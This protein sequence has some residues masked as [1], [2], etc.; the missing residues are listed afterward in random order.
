MQ[1]QQWHP[2][3]PFR[4]RIR[5]GGDEAL[6][7]SRLERLLREMRDQPGRG[8]I[9]HAGKDLIQV[10]TVEGDPRRSVVVKR[11]ARQG[12]LRDWWA[13]WHGTAAERSFD[14]AGFL[15]RQGL[16]TPEPWACVERWERGR[17]RESFF[18]SDYLEGGISFKDELVRLFAHEPECA[19][20]MERLALVA[21]AVRKLH[22]AGCQHR[23]LGN[24][25]IMLVRDD[26]LSDGYR[27]CFLDLNR[28]R[29]KRRLSS[30]DR[31]FDLSRIALP[32]DLRRVFFEMYWRAPP[33][34]RWLRRERFF[35]ILFDWHTRTRS[36]RHPWREG[37]R[38]AV[39]GHPATYPAPR[40]QWI[41]DRRSAQPIPTLRPRDRHRYYE[42]GRLPTLIG[43]TLPVLPCLARQAHRLRQ[44]AFTR[45]IKLEAALVVA[46][47]GAPEHL[48]HEKDLLGAL[49]IRDVFMRFH[50]HDD[51]SR[52]RRRLATFQELHSEGFRL[53]GGLLQDRRAVS[54]PASWEEFCRQV[55]AEAGLASEWLEFGHAINRVKWGLWGFNDYR[56]LVSCLPALR[57]DFPQVKLIGP[58][59]IDF[60][61]PQTLAAL[62]QLPPGVGWD[63][64]SMHLYVDRRGAP[65]NPQGLIDTLDK[66]ALARAAARCCGDRCGDGLIVSEVNWPLRGTGVYSPVG[67]PWESPGPRRRDPSVSEDE[68]ADYLLRYVLL[69]TCSG[70]V[71]Q[72]VV[73]R[74]AAHGFGL[75]DDRDPAGW[76]RRP[77]FEALRLW[78]EWTAGGTFIERVPI[79][80]ADPRRAYLLHCVNVVG[81][82]LLVGWAHESQVAA[83]TPVPV[84]QAR[85]ALGNKVHLPS[86]KH[87]RLGPR[88]VYAWG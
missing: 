39:H 58:A 50:H 8:S 54:D 73:W 24:Q 66:F 1:A 88:P 82:P 13:R 45:P 87:L 75:V 77:A 76:R 62:R 19:L 72:T 74:L 5:H 59:S 22:D 12:Y 10:R 9:L 25:N 53:S 63:A 4:V 57:Q 42:M 23:D 15:C 18:L 44:E 56:R 17:L 31:A 29:C 80:G 51:P 3:G 67:A 64:L 49:G 70:L 26:D 37:L 48:A 14:T 46:L 81:E 21:R 7:L 69:A 38:R 32:S 65:E 40:E 43:A 79:E 68:Y 55:L 28:A 78:L 34:R 86:D 41:W 47:D 20:F 36:W 71:R 11:F 6:A 60:D 35:R 30:R 61:L 83:R 27:V 85:D 84:R 2:L 33:D 16:G 52:R